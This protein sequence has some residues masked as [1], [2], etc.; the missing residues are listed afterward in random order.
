MTCIIAVSAQDSSSHNIYMYGG[1]QSG[2]NKVNVLGDIW[3]LTLPSFIWVQV[4]DS[5][6]LLHRHV[7]ANLQDHYMFVY[8][9]LEAQELDPCNRK[10]YNGIK[11]FDL[12]RLEW[13]TKYDYYD[14]GWKYL[15]PQILIDVIGG[16]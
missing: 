4:S 6:P 8:Q 13:T 16:K 15:V 7:C 11:L 9:G 14:G 1:T 2:R 5:E 3:I 12:S 10:G